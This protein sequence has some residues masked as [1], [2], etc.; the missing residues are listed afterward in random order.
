MAEPRK[1][2]PDLVLTVPLLLV[3]VNLEVL[4]GIGRAYLLSEVWTYAFG[5]PSSCVV[6]D[7]W[8]CR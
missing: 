6:G 1:P 7:V 4:E 5:V 2:Y 3:V 8:I